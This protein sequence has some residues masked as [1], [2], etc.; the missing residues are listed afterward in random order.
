MKRIAVISLL[1]V[2]LTTNY[3]Y[4]TMPIEKLQQT[5]EKAQTQE[6][7]QEE[8]EEL[9]NEV[10]ASIDLAD[11]QNQSIET[12]QI[13]VCTYVIAN[14]LAIGS[15]LGPFI[16]PIVMFLLLPQVIGYCFF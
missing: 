4:A 16:G 10:T 6:L 12:H 11:F 5:L 14:W 7:T 1:A 8:L 15:M 9:Y 2:F 13:D 3:A